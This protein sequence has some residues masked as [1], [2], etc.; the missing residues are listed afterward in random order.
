MSDPSNDP[1]DLSASLPESARAAAWHSIAHDG[2]SCRPYPLK[3]G[4]N[5][6]RRF[7]VAVHDS[8]GAVRRLSD[9]T[10]GLSRET[11]C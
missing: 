9:L 6:Q 2:E 11:I 8:G 5:A 1:F 3:E 7:R 4:L 10:N